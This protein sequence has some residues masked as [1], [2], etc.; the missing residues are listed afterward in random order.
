MKRSQSP[1]ILI[2]GGWSP[3]PLV[4]LKQF[5][6]SRQSIILQP[7]NLP[8]PPFPGTWCCHPKVLFMFA[9]FASLLWL[10]GAEHAS[11]AWNILAIVAVIGWFRI[12]AAVVVRTSI[13]MSAQSCLEV[14]REY[15]ENVLFLG[16]SWGGA[17]STTEEEL[18][19]PPHT[20]TLTRVLSFLG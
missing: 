12:L 13:E 20:T 10:A 3:G 1:V 16:F 9:A 7:R 15:D 5:M 17:V 2:V 4:Y 14:I 11:I 8:M 6:T 19:S 18:V